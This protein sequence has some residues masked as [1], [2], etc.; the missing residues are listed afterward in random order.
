[1]GDD[2]AL[3][4]RRR[5]RGLGMQIDKTSGDGRFLL[6]MQGGAEFPYTIAIGAIG[7]G[8]PRQIARG[9]VCCPDWNR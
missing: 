7:G 3:L 5:I 1:V 4:E 9:R 6:G 2:A 8:K